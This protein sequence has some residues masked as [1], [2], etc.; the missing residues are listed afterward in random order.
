MTGRVRMMGSRP[1]HQELRARSR[2]RSSLTEEGDLVLR[3]LRGAMG[4]LQAQDVELAEE[5]IAFDDKIDRRYLAIQEGIERCSPARR[6]SP[7]T[8][9][10][11][12]GC[13]TS[14]STSSGWPTT[15]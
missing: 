2:P 3:A 10:S 13:C 1:F 6:R 5:V 15:A 7:S 8:S 12:S 14:T 11:S 9:A 4:A